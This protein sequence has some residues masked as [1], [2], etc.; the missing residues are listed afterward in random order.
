MLKKLLEVE[1]FLL[2]EDADEVRPELVQNEVEANNKLFINY[3]K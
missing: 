3:Y 2:V 1:V